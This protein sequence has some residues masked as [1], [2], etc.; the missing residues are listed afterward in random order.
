MIQTTVL[1][2]SQNLL[3]YCFARKLLEWWSYSV[4]ANDD[5]VEGS[6][7]GFDLSL[8]GPTFSALLIHV[9]KAAAFA[10]AVV[11]SPPPPA[12]AEPPASQPPPPHGGSG[13]G[14]CEAKYGCRL[15]GESGCWPALP[16]PG[17]E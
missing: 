12:A 1:S 11:A 13:A 15:M 5:G 16:P 10:A 3:D 7:Q 2:P 9:L 14:P 4:D 8:L 6:D 17:R